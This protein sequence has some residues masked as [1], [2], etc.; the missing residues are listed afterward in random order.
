MR[1]NAGGHKRLRITGYAYQ[2]ED[3]NGRQ[4]GKGWGDR[5]GMQMNDER[6][7]KLLIEAMQEP[8]AP[9][10]LVERTCWKAR[11]AE[12]RLQRQAAGAR[13]TGA[14]PGKQMEKRQRSGETEKPHKEEA[15]KGKTIGPKG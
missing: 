4:I 3:R 9:K 13:K 10:R 6:I 7:G 15:A 14:Q 5:I 1:Q 12:A 2:T 8:T 11:S